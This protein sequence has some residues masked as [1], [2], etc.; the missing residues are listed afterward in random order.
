MLE[1]MK[2][3]GIPGL[4]LFLCAVVFVSCGRKVTDDM[5]YLALTFQGK[6]Y[7]AVHYEESSPML[8]A[9]ESDMAEAMKEDPP[10]A[11]LLGYMYAEST[12][13]GEMVIE[14]FVFEKE[15]D[16]KRLVNH[17]KDS[18]A[19][20]QGISDLRRDGKVVYMGLLEALRIAEGTG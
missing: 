16:A 6:G 13:T 7:T 8:T 4:A 9:L 2:K 19:F 12:E 5:T 18:A 10:Q 1:K 20:V 17:L 11:S 14:V 3:A 15:A